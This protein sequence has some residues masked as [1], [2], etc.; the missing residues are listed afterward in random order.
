MAEALRYER[1]EHGIG[2]I[3]IDRPDA[4]NALDST[5]RASLWTCFRQFRDDGAAGVA[6]ITGTGDKAFCAGGDLKEMSSSQLGV[7]PVDFLPQLNR[8]FQLDKPVIAAV[9]G[10][11]LGGGFL[12]AQMA[13]L[14]VAADH[15][16][17]AISEA[18]W[19][20]GAPWAAPLPW[21]IPPR[22]A[23]EMLM[24]GDS[25]SAARAYELGLVNKVVPSVELRATAVELARSILANAPLTVRAS[26]QMVYAAAEPSLAYGFARA[27]QLFEGVYLSADAQEG[28][29]AFLERRPPQ[30]S[31]K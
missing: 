15:A 5:A 3:T 23:L 14:C 18:K 10:V 8:N 25:I 12:L 29:R 28:P 9:N 24:T 7:P 31:G 27:E 26:R 22:V 20:R 4:A 30:W 6:V 17:F 13:D 1:D 21:L 16:K 11:A 2:W 19:G